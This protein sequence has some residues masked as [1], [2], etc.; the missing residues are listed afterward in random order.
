MGALTVEFPVCPG[1]NDHLTLNSM[2]TFRF[3]HTGLVFSVIKCNVKILSVELKRTPWWAH[4][5][6]NAKNDAGYSR[7][8]FP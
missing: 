7:H 6:L 8:F 1:V 3:P 4:R 2:S 5:L